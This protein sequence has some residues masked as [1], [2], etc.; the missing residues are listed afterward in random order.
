MPIGAQGR[1]ARLRP[2]SAICRELPRLSGPN[3]NRTPSACPSD[4]TDNRKVSICRAF[5]AADGTRTHDLLHG[6]QTL[7]RGLVTFRSFAQSVRLRTNH[8]YRT[9]PCPR[10][11]SRRHGTGL[12]SG[13]QPS[14]SCAH[15]AWRPAATRCHSSASAT[16][17]A[18]PSPRAC[19]GCSPTARADP[20]AAR[21]ATNVSHLAFPSRRD[22]RNNPCSRQGDAVGVP[23]AD[24]AR[25]CLGSWCG[26]GLLLLC[27]RQA[28]RCGRPDDRVSSQAGA[29][30]RWSRTPGRRA[31]CSRRPRGSAYRRSRPRRWRA[32]RQRGTP[33][34]C[35]IGRAIWAG[36]SEAA[37]LLS[38]GASERQRPASRQP[39]QL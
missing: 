6:K 16:P 32:A 14:G 35:R 27:R 1:P 21:V 33:T 23:F 28:R 19:G 20:A 24:V 31:R 17:S 13:A 18:T 39:V 34:A 8:W 26:D 12:S 22:L 38:W 2:K 5:Q 37:V 4:G 9:L 25:H 15:V 29:W 10:R 11:I 7:S 3:S 30:R 36:R